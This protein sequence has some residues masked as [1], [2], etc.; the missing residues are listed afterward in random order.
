MARTF[1][2][3][4]GALDALDPALDRKKDGLFNSE[5]GEPD[6]HVMVPL[7]RLMKITASPTDSEEL[8]GTADVRTGGPGLSGYRACP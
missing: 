7:V 1:S 4:G 8:A 5:L 2:G 3:G 6:C